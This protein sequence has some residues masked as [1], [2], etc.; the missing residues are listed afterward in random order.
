MEQRV[1]Q[2]EARYRLHEAERA[3]VR[4]RFAVVEGEA[5]S[6]GID[7]ATDSE[8]LAALSRELDRR[9]SSLEIRLHLPDFHYEH[10]KNSGLAAFD[11][12]VVSASFTAAEGEL[13]EVK[14]KIEIIEELLRLRRVLGLE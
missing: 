6:H 9:K 2:I 14:K 10:L 3:R 5:E 12:E 7:R 13:R 8:S 11:R 1:A 4:E